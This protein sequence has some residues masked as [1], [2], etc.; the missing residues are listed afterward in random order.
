[1]TGH[2]KPLLGRRITGSTG[3]L[4]AVSFISLAM[5][6]L[7]LTIAVCRGQ[8]TSYR[9]KVAMVSNKRQRM[10]G[11]FVIVP[12]DLRII[13]RGDTAGIS[14]GDY[15]KVEFKNGQLM[16]GKMSCDSMAWYH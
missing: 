16:A 9:V 7:I 14:E 6:A 5:I 15:V 12:D 11:K 13:C 3:R 8:D 2:N 10:E 4:L 1:M